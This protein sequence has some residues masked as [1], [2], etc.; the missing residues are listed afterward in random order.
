MLCFFISRLFSSRYF[1]SFMLKS[2]TR[3]PQKGIS[4]KDMKKIGSMHIFSIF[5][6]DLTF[7][8]ILN[9]VNTGGGII[10]HTLSIFYIF[11]NFFVFLYN[12]VI[13][14]NLEAKKRI[15]TP[16]DFTAFCTNDEK[17]PQLSK[18]RID[19][20]FL[21]LSRQKTETQP[22]LNR[23][24]TETQPKLSQSYIRPTLDLH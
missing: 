9:Q 20:F 14:Y 16:T 4:Y 6:Y 22:K 1:S 13:Y 15:F 21:F 2:T 8:N 12:W 11:N 19:G 5:H 10:R 7:I 18:L 3:Y 23:D 17:N 24:W